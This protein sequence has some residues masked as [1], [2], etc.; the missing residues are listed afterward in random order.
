MLI[1][2][3]SVLAWPLLGAVA[4]CSRS[5]PDTLRVGLLAP[6][7]GS[8]EVRGK[9]VLRGAQLAADELNTQPFK[10]SGQPVKMEIIGVDDRGDDAGAIEGARRLVEAGVI[11][12]LGPLYTSQA[13]KAIPVLAEAGLPHFITAAAADLLALGRGNVLRLLANDD[14]Q[15][16]AVASFVQETLRAQRIV[17]VHEDTAFGK[18]RLKDFAAEL[19]KRGGKAVESFAVDSKLD[20]GTDVAARIKAANADA[21]ALFSR[22]THLKSLFKSLQAVGHTDVAVIGL[23]GTRNK[24]VAASPVPVKALYATATAIDPQ[25]F[26]NGHRF[27]DAFAAKYRE[28]PVWGAHYAYDAVL[29]LAGAVAATASVDAA[30]LIE[31]LKAREPQTRVIEQMRFDASGEQRYASI[32]VYRVE[33]GA[34]QLQMRS[35]QW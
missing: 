31:R 14:L 20:V 10:V 32:A 15:M 33:S 16:R 19:N 29:A 5:L 13:Q 23:N 12:V 22:D 26:V 6:L 11:G 1:A 9:D 8:F 4:G 28:S 7:T 24:N 3:R 34:W 18:G 27:L 25:E 30:K 2:R 17:V 35:S 21:I